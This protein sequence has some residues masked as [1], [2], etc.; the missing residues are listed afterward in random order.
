M[1]T[2]PTMSNPP[3]VAAAAEPRLH[4]L[5]D[6]DVSAAIDVEHLT[7][8]LS[9]IKA[10]KNVDR[11]DLFSSIVSNWLPE[12]LSSPATST[13][14]W[15]KKRSF[16]EALVCLLPP[17][18]ADADATM[19]CDFLLRLLRAACM[20]GAGAAYRDDLET[21]V[22]RRLEQASL[23][24]LTIPAFSHT[25]DTL[26]DLRLVLRLVRKFV[27]ASDEAEA[28]AMVKVAKLV[29]SYL[30]E[31]AMDAELAVSDFEELATAVPGH[32]RAT[33]DG[34]Y[35]AVDTYFKAHPSLAKQER[36][37]LGGLIDPRK[38]SPEASLHAVHND[39]LPVRSVVQILFSEQSKLNRTATEWAAGTS[40]FSSGPRSPNLPFQ[41]PPDRCPSKRQVLAHQQETRRL[42]RDVARLQAQ[43]RAL[44]AQIDVLVSEKKK[45]GLF[46]WSSLLF[47]AADSVDTAVDDYDTGLERRTPRT[48]K[49][50]KKTMP[51]PGKTTPRKWRNSV[52]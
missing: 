7:R 31:A 24:E 49:D 45:K 2:P 3:L 16:V 36:K 25:C 5:H 28:A 42:Q 51:A 21:R 11:P 43:C 6:S 37:A 29:D 52:S 26:L 41:L 27:A 12:V 44:Q 13:A 8:T 33:D 40:S 38:L 10:K 47:S 18:T 9:A 23:E 14:A 50:V 46:K 17:E 35:Q 19:P 20:V 34:L 1:V 32:A 30:A 48:T 39:R 22:A 4:Q 15:T